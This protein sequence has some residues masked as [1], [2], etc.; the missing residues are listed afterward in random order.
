M[1]VTSNG[2]TIVSSRL[3]RNWVIS[4][5]VFE[6]DAFTETLSSRVTGLEVVSSVVED[7]LK[8]ELWHDSL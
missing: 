4:I 8:K 5:D 2:L 7:S 1:G 6:L 3:K